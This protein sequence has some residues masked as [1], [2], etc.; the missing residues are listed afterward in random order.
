M[1]PS[2]APIP[3]VLVVEDEPIVA[4]ELKS[5]L[6]RLGFEVVGHETSGERALV[7]ARTTRPDV[8]LMDI[9]LDGPMDGIEAARRLRD[10]R[11]TS[12]SSS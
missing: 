8:V 3:R 5:Y 11:T 9:R 1:T 4:L 7:A 6:A 10:E 2:D 12:R